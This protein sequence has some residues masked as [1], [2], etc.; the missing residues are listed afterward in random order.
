MAEQKMNQE[1]K[2]LSGVLLIFFSAI[3]LPFLMA[4]EGR[5]V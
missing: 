2:R 3:F 1:E 4:A 5:A